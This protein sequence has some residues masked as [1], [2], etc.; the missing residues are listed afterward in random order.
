MED[1]MR[2]TVTVLADAVTDAA[3]VV[4]G[5]RMR[6]SP[7]DVERIF[8]WQL[9]P[10]GLCKDSVC[11]PVPPA[12]DVVTTD[13]IDLRRFAALLARPLAIDV[14]ERTVHLGESA[15]TRGEHLASL[16]APDFTLPDL[17]GRQHSLSDYRGQRVLLV[18]HA[19]W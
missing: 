2:T 1:D 11:I 17:S 16:R 13:G 14:D 4:D 12:S 18:A 7:A 19:S 6:L 5:D 8:G 9:K 10:Q 15:A 3:A